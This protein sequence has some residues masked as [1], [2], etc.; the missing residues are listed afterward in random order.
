MRAALF[1][2][3]VAFSASPVPAQQIR[4]DSTFTLVG[5]VVDYQTGAPLSGARVEIRELKQSAAADSSGRFT[6]PG[7]SGGVYTFVTSQLGYITNDEASAIR[8]GDILTVA[9]IP[10]PVILEGIAVTA[11]RLKSR[12]S[13]VGV[14]VRA[15]DRDDLVRASGQSVSS[16]LAHRDLILVPCRTALAFPSTS[17]GDTPAFTDCTYLRGQTVPVKLWI[18]EAP[19]PGGFEQLAAYGL[20]EIYAIEIYSALRMVRVYTTWFME[21]QAQSPGTLEPVCI[22]C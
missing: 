14:S 3:V 11:D 12:R 4:N 6:I 21:R 16:F 5:R 7:L 2:V 19:A 13:S 1:L 10:K 15:Y 9:L 8:P 20:E 22:A 18:D 17:G